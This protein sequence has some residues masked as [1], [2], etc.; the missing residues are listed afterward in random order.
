M[1]FW[2][3]L[4]HVFIL[5]YA[6]VAV[7]SGCGYGVP[8]VGRPP[9]KW[10]RCPLVERILGKDEVVGSMPNEGSKTHTAMQM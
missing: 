9:L 10:Q 7:E 8:A 6:V 2:A 3:I 4:E 1:R 5:E